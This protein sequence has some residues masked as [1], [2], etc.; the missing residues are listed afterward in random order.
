MLLGAVVFQSLENR[1]SEGLVVHNLTESLEK[2]LLR[3]YNA[4]KREIE[5]ILEQVR[6]IV[7][8]ERQAERANWTFYSSLYFVGS[9]ITTIGELKVECFLT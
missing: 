9:V 2:D 4:T 1:P 6:A 8:Q 3:K 7:D 5:A